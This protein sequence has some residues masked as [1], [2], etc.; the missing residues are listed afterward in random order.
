MASPA[1]R[2]AEIANVLS[3]FVS[4]RENRTGPFR[5]TVAEARPPASA[6]SE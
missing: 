4:D 6:V 2:R 3:E 5:D 1:G